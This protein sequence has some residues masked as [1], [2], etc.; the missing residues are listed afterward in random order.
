MTMKNNF[1]EI[2]PPPCS[3][4]TIMGYNKWIDIEL[5]KLIKMLNTPTFRPIDNKK[6]N[7]EKDN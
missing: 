6:L 1:K 5:A 2:T 7:Y 3:P 4:T